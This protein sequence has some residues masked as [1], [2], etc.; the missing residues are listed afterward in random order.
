[1][2]GFSGDS[3]G[4]AA[5]RAVDGC[6]SRCVGVCRYFVVAVALAACGSTQGNGGPR[7]AA[8]RTRMALIRGGPFVYGSA[9]DERADAVDASPWD[10]RIAARVAAELP[11]SQRSLAPFWIDR[12]LVTVRDYGVF[13][14]DR[15]YPPPGP[16]VGSPGGDSLIRRHTWAHVDPPVALLAHPVSLVS[17]RDAEA[18]CQWRGARLPTEL[19]WEKAARGTRGQRYPW[20][21]AYNP[22]CLDGPETGPGDTTPVL[23][24]LCGI[25]PFGL[26]DAAGNVRQWTATPGTLPDH[27]VVR[28][29]DFRS[30]PALARIAARDELPRETR[31]P[32]LGF[33]CAADQVP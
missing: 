31:D 5:L 23:T 4:I 8:A 15:S 14:R 17:W 21:D 25:S 6:I 30:P 22:L 20:G 2:A 9:P 1:M 10:R 32:S 24:F 3:V 29:S 13:V 27:A 16:P 11:P 26:S 12:T 18:Y 19:E 33:R 7:S 28:G